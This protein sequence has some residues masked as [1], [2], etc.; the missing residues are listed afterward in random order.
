MWYIMRT[1]YSKYS[2]LMPLSFF[3]LISAG[4]A[5]EG[6]TASLVRCPSQWNARNTS[7]AKWSDQLWNIIFIFILETVGIVYISYASP[8]VCAFSSTLAHTFVA[9]CKNMSSTKWS[10]QFWD[11]YPQF[12][13]LDKGH[14]LQSRHVALLT[15]S[16]CNTC[17]HMPS[18][19]A[20]G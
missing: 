2:N 19:R 5:T 11:I 10:D 8:I 6:N 12:Y 20:E 17:L 7:L 9:Q 14:I 3:L 16:Q 4:N 13:S 15:C 18:W 1:C